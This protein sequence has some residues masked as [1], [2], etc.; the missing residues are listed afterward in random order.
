MFDRKSENEKRFLKIRK[1]SFLCWTTMIVF[2]V[3]HKWAWLKNVNMESKQ[4]WG[5]RGELIELISCRLV[6][7]N[8][9][10]ERLNQVL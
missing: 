3:A 7:F 5:K 8:E 10:S 2:D 6:E 9:Q 1:K 4:F